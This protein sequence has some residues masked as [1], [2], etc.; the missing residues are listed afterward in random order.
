MCALNVLLHIQALI[1][2]MLQWGKLAEYLANGCK[3]KWSTRVVSTPVVSHCQ[4]STRKIEVCDG[5]GILK[6]WRISN[7]HLI[8]S[9]KLSAFLFVTSHLY[10]R[11]ALQWAQSFFG[12]FPDLS[13]KKDWCEWGFLVFVLSKMVTAL[14]QW[15]Q[16]FQTLF[17]PGFKRLKQNTADQPANEFWHLK[18]HFAAVSI[19]CRKD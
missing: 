17:R 5:K 4:T 13:Q 2:S 12:L 9:L 19:R 11:V 3:H 7:K 10:G 6:H 1:P 16:R 18:I 15:K 14:R 8:S